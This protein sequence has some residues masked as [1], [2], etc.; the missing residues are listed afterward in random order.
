MNWLGPENGGE[1][2]CLQLG[3][4]TSGAPQASVLGPALFNI[5]IDDMDEAIESYIGALNDRVS[6]GC[7]QPSASAGREEKR[8][9]LTPQQL[10]AVK[11]KKYPTL[12][13][14]YFCVLRLKRPL[15]Q[16]VDICEEN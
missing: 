3:T 4:V 2:C 5:F 13:W 14:D 7:L 12:F 6:P 8:W 16:S 9:T 10:L 1:W 15:K 11:G